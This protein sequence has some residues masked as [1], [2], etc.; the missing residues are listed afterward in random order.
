MSRVM[1]A[2]DGKSKT[3]QHKIAA[4]I[5]SRELDHLNFFDLIHGYCSDLASVG[6]MKQSVNSLF[7][8]SLAAAVDTVCGFCHAPG[9]KEADCRR[10]KNKDKK[11]D[12]CGK[13]Y[14]TEAQCHKK[15]KDQRK[16]S[17]PEAQPAAQQ[18]ALP[19]PVNNTADE[20][21]VSISQSGMMA[22]MRQLEGQND[23][24]NIRDVPLPVPTQSRLQWLCQSLNP[25]DAQELMSSLA[26]EQHALI[27]SRSMSQSNNP[28]SASNLRPDTKISLS[29]CDGIGCL[30]MVM[31]RIRADI[32]W[33][34]A[35]ENDEIARIICQNA[36]PPTAHFP[37]VDHSWKSNVFDITEADIAQFG[38]NVIKFLGLG[39]PCEDQ[40]KLR[41]IM[42]AAQRRAHQK[43]GK[44]P[45]PGLDGPKRCSVSPVPP[46]HVMGEE[47]QSR[48]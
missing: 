27:Q 13:Q 25:Q 6:D 42:S 35:V 36:N 29:L 43:S 20:Q 21:R 11:C 12:Y 46:D 3:T 23:C 47:A 4:D 45:R 19:Q 14:H 9:H 26:A 48:C 17:P 33:A 1:K 18:L 5:N 44:D 41:L 34:V 28:N 32:T 15:R 22:I 40:S 38:P 24:F 31:Q 7:E 39:P 30:W 37:G 16:V 10:K 8:E 2:F